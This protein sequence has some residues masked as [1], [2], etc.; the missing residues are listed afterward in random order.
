ME[1]L[2]KLFG[3]AKEN[4]GFLLISAA[5]IVL[6]FAVAYGAEF[7]FD[8]KRGTKRKSEKF[9]VHRL[10]LIAMMSAIA[11]ILN[12]FSIP[13]WFLP[14]FY[15]IDLSELPVLIGAFTMGP[16]AGITIE[17]VKIVLNL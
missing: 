2:K 15:K 1:N 12:L 5:V 14:S 4:V 10:T 7:L 11:I 3:T 13:L 8:K 17:F 9:R 16:V 6:I